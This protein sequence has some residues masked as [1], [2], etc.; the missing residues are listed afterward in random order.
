MFV[1]DDVG[2]VSTFRV[3]KTCC[4]PISTKRKKTH[5][6]DSNVA[7]FFWRVQVPDFFPQFFADLLFLPPF[8]SIH[9]MAR[10]NFIGDDPG[11][12]VP[13]RSLRVWNH[14]AWIT[15]KSSWNIFSRRLPKLPLRW[16]RIFV[17]VN[18]FWLFFCWSGL[19]L[20]MWCGGLYGEVCSL[21]FIYVFFVWM[22]ILIRN[23][24]FET[25][26]NRNVL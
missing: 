2:V 26:P 13:E 12:A 1:F 24:G 14:T 21:R 16:G 5:S 17:E 15:F 6:N 20:A 8:M 10:P 19:A 18:V 3:P 4:L 22:P 7:F 25:W 9:S 23:C 11:E